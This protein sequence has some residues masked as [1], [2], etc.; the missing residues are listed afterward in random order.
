MHIS[1][2]E[3]HLFP[4]MFP[5]TKN[6]PRYL[7]SSFQILLLSKIVEYEQLTKKKKV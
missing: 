5:H 4:N 7:K 3:M 6:L 2:S 1:E